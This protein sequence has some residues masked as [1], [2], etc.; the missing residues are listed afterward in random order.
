[1]DV[2]DF[3]LT[4]TLSI[5]GASVTGVIGGP[6]V[7]TVTVNT[8]TGGGVLRLDVPVGAT[9]TDL[10]GNP[11]AGLPYTSGETYDVRLSRIYLPLVLRN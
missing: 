7:Y 2:S 6:A 3:A 9:I 4:K 11:L 5:A 10:A 1:V 8:G